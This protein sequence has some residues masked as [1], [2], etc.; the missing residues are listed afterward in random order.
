MAIL[1]IK[2][3]VGPRTIAV[4]SRNVSSNEYSSVT[5]DKERYNREDFPDDYADAKFVRH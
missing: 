5:P 2:R 4:K 1:R 3:L